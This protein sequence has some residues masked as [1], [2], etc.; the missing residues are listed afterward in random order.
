VTPHNF[1]QLGLNWV[2]TEAGF[3]VKYSQ[4]H[5]ITRYPTLHRNYQAIILTRQ[6]KLL[7]WRPKPP[8]G[9]TP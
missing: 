8:T 6:V 2:I 5:S 7:H 3:A 1:N 9:R 4:S